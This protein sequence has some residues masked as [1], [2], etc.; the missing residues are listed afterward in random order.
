MSPAVGAIQT[1]SRPQRRNAEPP[2]A[3]QFTPREALDRSARRQPLVA[4]ETTS[5]IIRQ[6]PV[7][8]SGGAGEVVRHGWR[9]P[10]AIWSSAP[11]A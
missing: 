11:L 7:R 1:R 3:M 4:N 8:K 2:T 10:F 9:R 5:G 6:P